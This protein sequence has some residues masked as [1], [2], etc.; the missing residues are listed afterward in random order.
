MDIASIVGVVGA[1]LV[2]AMATGG[3]FVRFI[4]LP[5]IL[6]VFGGTFLCV[7]AKS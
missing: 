2:I 3:D 1:L 6:I 5:S 4:D 7:L